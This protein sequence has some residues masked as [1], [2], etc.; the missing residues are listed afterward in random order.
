MW[1]EGS[2]IVALQSAHTGWPLL[3]TTQPWSCN[4]RNSIPPAGPLPAPYRSQASP[5]HL[6]Y[7][8]SPIPKHQH[9]QF[10][11][12]DGSLSSHTYLSLFLLSVATAAV[13]KGPPLSASACDPDTPDNHT[14]HRPLTPKRSNAGCILG[15]LVKLTKSG[16][17]MAGQ[18]LALVPLSAAAAADRSKLHKEGE[19]CNFVQRTFACTRSH[20]IRGQQLI[21]SCWSQLHT[22]PLP[23]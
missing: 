13:L 9:I 5:T 3:T 11:C 15:Q 2:Q 6:P 14:S 1:C 21:C 20:G 10:A 17:H 18:C 4:N 8:S 22:V 16:Q 23:L 12:S 19:C 7:T